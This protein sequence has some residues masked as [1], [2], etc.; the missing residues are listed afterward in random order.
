MKKKIDLHIHSKGSFDGRFSLEEIFKLGEKEQ[1]GCI[2]IT[3]HN[4][5]KEINNY[6]RDKDSIVFKSKKSGMLV[7]PGVEI[8][9]RV[10]EILNF[11]GRPTKIHILA[12]GFNRN[13]NTPL[14]KILKLKEEND[15]KFDLWYLFLAKKILNININ[16]KDIAEFILRKRQLNPGFQTLGKNDVLAFLKWKNIQYDITDEELLEQMSFFRP[17][18]R[19]NLEAKDIIKLVK[20]AG[21]LTIMA[22]PKTNLDRTKYK[23]DLLKKLISY[24]IDG[25]EYSAKSCDIIT[26]NYLLKLKRKNR[27][28]YLTGGSDYHGT[29]ILKSRRIG[30]SFGKPL[31]GQNESF[32]KEILKRQKKIFSNNKEYLINC[33]KNYNFSLKILKKYQKM[34]TEINRYRIKK[35]IKKEKEDEERCMT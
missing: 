5:L 9:C 12:Y 23:K 1:C 35:T 28:L 7:V 31:I 25:F 27:N 22:H 10:S 14:M 26:Q 6:F 21:G 30:Y 3:D 11:K 20:A 15:K 32:L 34:N 8:T 24:G 13:E 18:R 4:S 17:I 29:E 16:E 2:S 19:L 33:K